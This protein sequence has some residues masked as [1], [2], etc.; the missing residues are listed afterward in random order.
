MKNVV[1]ICINIYRTFR[2]WSGL[3]RFLKCSIFIRE[4]ER[5]HHY[6]IVIGVSVSLNFVWG[7]KAKINIQNLKNYLDFLKF[8]NKYGWR[9]TA[10]LYSIYW[11][12]SKN[13]QNWKGFASFRSTRLGYEI[14]EAKSIKVCNLKILEI[15]S[16]KYLKFIHT[17]IKAISYKSD[18]ANP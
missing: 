4:K 8:S 6:Y 5:K 9:W 18:L 1:P 15:W 17:Y 14:Y 13:W 16:P 2:T 11:S 3:V 10:R 7:D 12:P